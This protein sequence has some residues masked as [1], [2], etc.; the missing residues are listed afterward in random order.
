[1]PADLHAQALPGDRVLT[2]SLP[3]LADHALPPAAPLDEPDPVADLSPRRQ[4]EAEAAV[5]GR[6]LEGVR[7]AEQGGA[8]ETPCA[9]ATAFPKITP[10]AKAWAAGYSGV[11]WK[12][13]SK[14][15]TNQH[16]SGPTRGASRAVG[17]HWLGPM[18]PLARPPTSSPNAASPAPTRASA[19]FAGSAAHCRAIATSSWNAPMLTRRSG[20]SSTAS[21]TTAPAS[22]SGDSNS[23]TRISV[24]PAARAPSAAPRATWP[25]KVPDSAWRMPTRLARGAR[26]LIQPG[27]PRR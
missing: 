27:R 24:K 16:E 9:T 19:V 23:M 25:A 1:M 5:E 20:S 3:R 13:R 12:A 10:T 15:S 2:E 6:G 18:M 14:A 22:R 7:D 4:V 21:R 8:R 11:R 17:S 26:R